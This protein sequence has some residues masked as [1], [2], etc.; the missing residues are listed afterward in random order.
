MKA[1]LQTLILAVSLLLFV[2][3]ASA[4]TLGTAMV[5]VTGENAECYAVNLSNTDHSIQMQLVDSSGTV[6][7]QTSS[8]TVIAGRGVS[9]GTHAVNGDFVYCKF[10]TSS[11]TSFRASMAVFANNGSDHLSVEAK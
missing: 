9:S 1:T 3:A 8:A 11:P 10:I 6:L 7:S 2:G 4:A 5:F